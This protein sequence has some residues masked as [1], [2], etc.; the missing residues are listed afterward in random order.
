MPNIKSIMKK[1]I[2]ISKE[3]SVAQAIRQILQHNISRLMVSKEGD[4]V[5]IITEKDLGFFLLADNTE[6]NL[7]KIPLTKVM[8]PLVTVDESMKIKEGAQIMLDRK[9]GSL[10]INSHGKT[11]GIITKT[12]LARHYLQKYVGKKRVGDFMTVS[13]VSMYEDD[14]IHE[15]A[16]MMIKEKVSRIILKNQSDAITGIITFRDLFRIALTLGQEERTVD[17]TDS[18]ISVISTRK[19]FLSESGFGKTI[20][21][22]EAMSKKV[23][24]ADY[25]D[26]MITA[27]EIILDNN[28][29]GVGVLV[30]GKLSGILSKTDVTR[31][32]VSV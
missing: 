10:G 25:N 12:D 26:D 8:K 3:S 27:C 19:G 6:E 14:P 22:K 32:L 20:L 29:N 23:V 16:A 24:T 31:A 4:L 9:I 5:G 15:I 7:D 28:V 17:N 2:S 1:P 13:Y 11:V 30:N 18:I 21:S